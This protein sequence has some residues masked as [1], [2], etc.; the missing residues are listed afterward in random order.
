[1]SNPYLTDGRL[2]I[3]FDAPE[4][5]RWWS[6][7]QSLVAT[8]DE[9]SAPV[10]VWRLYVARDND[11]LTEKHQNRCSGVLKTIGEVIYC[12]ACRYFLPTDSTVA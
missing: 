6:G 8:L 3:P 5:Y 9:L 10:E 4:K 11:L 7:G 2:V 1:M 12:P